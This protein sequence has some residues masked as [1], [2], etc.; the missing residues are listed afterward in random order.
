MAT[1]LTRISEKLYKASQGKGK[2]SAQALD[3]H[4]A[5]LEKRAEAAVTEDK[6]K[7]VV[8]DAVQSAMEEMRG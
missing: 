1:K 3:N 5:E 2:S 7:R 8:K 4:V 6:L